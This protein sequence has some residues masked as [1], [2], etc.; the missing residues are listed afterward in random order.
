[1]AR[2]KREYERLTQAEDMIRDLAT[3]YKDALW[4]VIPSSIMVLSITNSD[5][6][7]KN[8]CLAK[9]KL[10]KGVEQ[11]VM[12]L[13]NIKVRYV[14]ELYGSDWSKWTEAQKQWIIFH[15]LMHV[16]EEGDQLVK[17][18]CE[19]F[20]MIIDAAGISWVDNAN[21]PNMLTSDVEFDLEL[22]PGLDDY[23]KDEEEANKPDLVFNP[24]E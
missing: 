23:K 2:T 1:M 3:K 12:E 18:D 6:S 21:L 14:I 20:K 7:E 16:H 9:V 22:R 5:R 10:M 13:N 19:D 11:A 17:H 15:E 4:R 8:H 24:E